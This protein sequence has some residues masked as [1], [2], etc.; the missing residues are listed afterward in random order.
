M[1]MNM[2]IITIVRA[3]PRAPS[4]KC[5]AVERLGTHCYYINLLLL[6]H[7]TLAKSVDL[8]YCRGERG[9]GREG[10]REKREERREKREETEREKRAE[11]REKR[12]ERER[13]ERERERERER[14][15]RYVDM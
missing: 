5:T 2:I 12:E 15:D 13:E 3:T 14:I 8:L 4:S 10:E 1:M 6:I 9:V 7:S 11:R